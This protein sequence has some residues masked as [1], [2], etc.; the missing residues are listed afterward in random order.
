MPTTGDI[1][2]VQILWG[3]MFGGQPASLETAITISSGAT[4]PTPGAVLGTIATPSLIDQ[5]APNEFRFFDPPVNSSPI[6]IPVTA[7]QVISVDLEF[8]NQNAGNAFA[9]SIEFDSDGIQ[10]GV[11]SVFSIPGGWN[12][13]NL[14]GV[15][16]DFG[17]RAIL[18][19][20]PEPGG[21]VLFLLGLSAF[22]SRRRR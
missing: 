6:Q 13:A 20:I 19:P 3:S 7:G 18:D 15:T 4:F 1:V 17:I 12:D 8:F 21:A 11:N 22:L 9:P 5:V 14:L 2:G 16:G 10:A